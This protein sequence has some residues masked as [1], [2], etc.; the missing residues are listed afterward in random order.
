MSYSFSIRA[1]SLAAAALTISDK[2]NEV[3][4]TQPVHAVDRDQAEAAAAAFVSLVGEPPEGKELAVTVSGWVSKSEDNLT[5]AAVSVS[6]SHI[7]AVP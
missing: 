6:A 2:L 1:A 3:V 7:D 4:E 5:G